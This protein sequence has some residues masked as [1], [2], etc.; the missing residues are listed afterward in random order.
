MLSGKSVKP[1]ELKH[2]LIPQFAAVGG[3]QELFIKHNGLL[4]FGIIPMQRNVADL[5][6][7]RAV[8]IDFAPADGTCIVKYGCKRS[9]QLLVSREFNQRPARKRDALVEVKVDPVVDR[10]HLDDPVVQRIDL[11]RALV[12]VA[13]QLVDRDAEAVCDGWDQLHIRIADPFLPTRYRLR[14]DAEFPGKRFLRFP[15]PMAQR[16]DPFP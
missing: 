15:V 16:L 6:P 4:P 10:V 14:R 11:F 13:E 9:G 3:A 12:F 2:R 5:E 8:D 1:G 7:V